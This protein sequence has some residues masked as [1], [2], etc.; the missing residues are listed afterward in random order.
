MSAHR[1]GF[2]L[3]AALAVLSAAAAPAPAPA[4]KVVA[5]EVSGNR[6]VP[7]ADILGR[8]YLRPGSE[9]SEDLLNEDMKKIARAFDAIRS[10]RPERT[11]RPDGVA[12][13]LHVVE[14]ER[15]RALRFV[16]EGEPP[17]D[18]S[19]LKRA[20]GLEEKKPLVRDQVRAAALRV[21]AACVSAGRPDAR[22]EL[23]EKALDEGIVI[24]RVT[25]GIAGRIFAIRFEGLKGFPESAAW[26]SIESRPRA[27]ILFVTV[28]GGVLEPD[29]LEKDRFALERRIREEGFLDALVG[30]VRREAVLGG[31]S[32]VFHLTEGPRYRVREV[33][34]EGAVAVPD[35][36]LREAL[37]TKAGEPWRQAAVAA[38]VAAIRGLYEGRARVD[39][40][41]TALPP[42]PVEGES[43]VVQAYRIEE[44]ETVR[45]GRVRIESIGETLETR[46]EVIRRELLFVEN[47]PPPPDAIERSRRRLLKTGFFDIRELRDPRAIRYEKTAD[48]KV[49]DVVVRL[50]DAP[51]GRYELTAGVAS[52]MGLFGGFSFV[53]RN[54]DLRDTPA[55]FGDLFRGTAFKG[56]GQSLSLTARLGTGN[57]SHDVSLD[58]KEP[59]FFGR[60]LGFR[61]GAWWRG[62]RREDW[63]ESRLGTGFGF[64]KQ[65]SDAFRTTAD[66]RVESVTIAEVTSPTPPDVANEEGGNSVIALALGA[67]LDRRDDPVLPGRGWRLGGRLEPGTGSGTFVKA[68][69]FGDRYWTLAEGEVGPFPEG[70]HVLTLRGRVGAAAGSPPTFERFYAGGSGGWGLEGDRVG[71]VRGFAYRSVGPTQMDDP[72]GGRFLGVYNLEYEFPIYGRTDPRRDP[73]VARMEYVRGAFFLDA[74]AASNSPGVFVLGQAS[75]SVG[76]G[77]RIRPEFLG[78]GGTWVSVDVGFPILKGGG[79]KSQIFSFQLGASR[80][81]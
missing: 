13:V 24:F 22:V 78:L 25:G 47:E 34:I 42:R 75:A 63:A 68:E 32:V 26:D 20:S 69:V 65:W 16:F 45:I 17:A 4:P 74:G 9:F 29:L 46:D 76:F 48:P 6:E 28:R 59:W 14:Y 7:T 21:H 40:R 44:G 56:A 73:R 70:K 57:L 66:F 64:F 50:Q 35:A 8:M 31:F 12:I 79:G 18:E 2:L 67:E 54:F 77:L 1:D 61:A 38:D 19:E 39:T 15:I 53:Q 3:A 71:T 55:G 33:R 81:F 60:P 30:P 5:V 58:F 41:V 23:D 80:E 37:R 72:V 36:A 10:I 51:T 52:D 27:K 11:A 43:S 62:Y 49:R